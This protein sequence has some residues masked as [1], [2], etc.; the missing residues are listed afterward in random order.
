MSAAQWWTGPLVAFDLETTGPDPEDARIVTAHVSVI[1]ADG[2]VSQSTDMLVDP[3]V[4]IP[5]GATAVHGITTETARQLGTPAAE[6]VPALVDLLRDLGATHPLVA[7]NAAYDFTVMD[8]EA[9]RHGVPP[10]AP[11][12]VVDPF[13]LDKQIDPYRKGRRTLTA[14]CE[15][16]RVPFT[17]A[18]QASADAVAAVALVRA[19]GERA[20]F[21]PPAELHTR[22]VAWRAEQ[23]ASLEAYFRRNDPTA[24]VAREWPVLPYRV[25][26]PA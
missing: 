10:F 26:V 3:G 5:E 12:V 13:V 17:N 14:A 4:E 15:H 21:P 20:P 18:H 2:T 22:Q 7:F 24:T 6:A 25:E 11:A 8:R 9:R 19:I 23:S 16:Y 1:A